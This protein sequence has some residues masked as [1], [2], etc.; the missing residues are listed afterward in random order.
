MPTPRISRSKPTT[1]HE[2]S[3]ANCYNTSR[4]IEPLSF[5]IGFP[6]LLESVGPR[7]FAQRPFPQV[8]RFHLDCFRAQYPDFKPERLLGFE[9]YKD[10][11]Q[12]HLSAAIPQQAPK[13]SMTLWD[14][15]EQ[16]D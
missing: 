9:R 10:D 1:F 11:V 13:R 15:L 4:L 7:A 5:Y 2:C 14:I 6:S 8:I 16:V 12:H 3:A